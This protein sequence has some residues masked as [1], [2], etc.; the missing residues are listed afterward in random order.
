MPMQTTWLEGTAPAGRVSSTCISARLDEP[1]V[2]P[3]FCRKSHEA[4]NPATTSKSCGG[5]QDTNI[6]Q[7]LT[8]AF[9]KII[10]STGI[11]GFLTIIMNPEI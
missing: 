1:D 10:A 5:M 8:R 6:L 3:W 2:L 9:Y 4:C 7:G 11:S